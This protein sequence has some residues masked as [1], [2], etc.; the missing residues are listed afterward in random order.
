MK[1]IN[2]RQITLRFDADDKRKAEI[3]AEDQLRLIRQTTFSQREVRTLMVDMYLSGAERGMREALV[4]N[5]WTFG[6]RSITKEADY[7]TKN[8]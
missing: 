2:D 4:Q 5:D 7:E 3:L 6:R 1:I 8:P